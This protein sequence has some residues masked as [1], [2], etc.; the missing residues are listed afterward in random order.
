MFGNLLIII[1]PTVD[2]RPEGVTQCLEYSVSSFKCKVLVPFLPFTELSCS[3][4][5]I[6]L[7]KSAQLKVVCFVFTSKKVL[8]IS[9]YVPALQGF[10]GC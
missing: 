1:I 8:F 7:R 4:S 2:K 9:K 10:L 3:W 5:H 6:I